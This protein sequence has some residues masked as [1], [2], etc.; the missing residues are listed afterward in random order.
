[1]NPAR[2]M[3][4]GAL[5]LALGAG[6]GTRG[7]PD[8]DAVAALAPTGAVR[9]GFISSSIY[10]VRDPSTNDVKGVAADL[11]RDLARRL[12]VPFAPVV[13]TSP[14]AVLAAA[15]AGDIDVALMGI[16]AERAAVI[17]FGGAYMEVEQ[18]VLVRAGLPAATLTDIDRSGWRMGVLDK[19][20]ADLA[21]SKSLKSTA[22]VRAASGTELFALFAQGKVDM[23]AATTTALFGEAAKNPGSRVLSG[24]LLVEPIGMGVPKGRPAALA[25]IER[26]IEDAKR[27]GVVRSAIEQAGLR[28]V[29]VAPRK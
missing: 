6:C 10:A 18:T 16:N 26:Y 27:D 24:R 4:T 21:L 8:S 13:L 20:G 2:A 7:A 28:G 29:V 15:K 19:S 3:A 25:Y 9:V 12:G 14:P 23:I 22:I 11:G 5:A 1:M 17:D